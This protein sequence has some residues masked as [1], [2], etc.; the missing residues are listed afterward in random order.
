MDREQCHLFIVQL[1]LDRHTLVHFVQ[2]DGALDRGDLFSAKQSD[3]A[4]LGQ[5]DIERLDV[6]D[7]LTYQFDLKRRHIVCQN[8]AVP[9]QNQSPARGYR[10]RPNAVTLGE[11]CVVIVF[12]DLQI[13]ETAGLGKQQHPGDDR[14][15]NASNDEELLL[16]PD[17]FYSGLAT[18]YH[19]PDSTQEALSLPGTDEGSPCA[20]RP[21]LFALR[22]SPC[23]CALRSA[24]RERSRVP[25]GWDAIPPATGVGAAFLCTVTDVTVAGA[26]L[27]MSI[28]GA[29][30]VPASTTGMPV[31]N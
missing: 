6:A 28:G 23:A 30:P 13:E 21:A 31:R 1:Q 5:R 11:F 24:L 19:R 12:E 17:V 8:D 26:D 9:I 25:Y 3:G 27:I 20:L 16:S 22:S 18:A 2:Q 10:F 15:D 29:A 7:L 4:Q 14:R